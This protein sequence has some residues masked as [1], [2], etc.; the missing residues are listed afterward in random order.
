M[1]PPTLPHGDV[2]RTINS[3]VSEQHQDAVQWQRDFRQSLYVE[4][5]LLSFLEELR[6]EADPI[7]IYTMS[8][9]ARAVV[10][11]EALEL[12]KHHNAPQLM[13]IQEAE[14][15][16]RVSTFDKIVVESLESDVCRM[17]FSGEGL[18][19]DWD[20]NTQAEVLED[21]GTDPA[22]P[23]LGKGEVICTDCE[24]RFQFGDQDADAF[25]QKHG[26]TDDEW[27]LV[28]DTVEGE[29]ST[30]AVYLELGRIGFLR[31]RDDVYTRDT[32]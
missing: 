12:L 1:N 28:Q 3:F 31:E 25:C 29:G 18:D 7:L 9:F 4:R 23:Q 21:A 16:L 22:F 24:G 8:H 14:C 5:K 30:D 32:Y 11:D 19:G 20:A 6:R 2:G 17:V 10:G 26:I 27:E 15:H 13:L